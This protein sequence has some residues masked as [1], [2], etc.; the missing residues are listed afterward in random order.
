MSDATTITTVKTKRKIATSRLA[1]GTLDVFGPPDASGKQPVAF[2]YEFDPSKWTD[3]MVRLTAIYGAIQFAANT[4][5]RIE[6]PS[7]ANVRAVLDKLTASLA[8]GT[9]EPGRH[10]VI[11][12]PDLLTRAIAEAT[13]TDVTVMQADIADR[14]VLDADGKPVTDAR[15]RNK[16]VF[17]KAV[18]DNIA[19]DPKV[20]PI[21]ARLT[22]EE[23][24]RLA[25]AAR[26]NKGATPTGVLDLFKSAPQAE[27]AQ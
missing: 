22:R 18:L 20:A 16:R 17:T 3:A 23:A 7:P 10:G 26:E 8:D 19:C 14:L 25:K 13:G 21:L 2:S 9:F 4:Y 27:A 24:D 15:G 1:D 11:G 12:E 6:D 5:N